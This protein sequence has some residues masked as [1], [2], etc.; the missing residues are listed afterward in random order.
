MFLMSLLCDKDTV[1]NGKWHLYSMFLV[2]PLL[3]TLNNTRH[4]NT[5]MSEAAMQGASSSGALKHFLTKA[6]NNISMPSRSHTRWWNSATRS[7]LRIL[8]KGVR[9]HTELQ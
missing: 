8:P 6:S 9:L 1:I 4:M 2:F 3:I 7:I 5:L